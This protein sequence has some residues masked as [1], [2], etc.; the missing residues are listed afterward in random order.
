MSATGSR[1][2]IMTEGGNTISMTTTKPV[3]SNKVFVGNVPFQCTREEFQ[4]SFMKMDGFVNA[5]IIR[6]YKSKLSR[7]FGFVV[8]STREHAEKLL[9]DRNVHFKDR[10]LRFSPYSMK[11]HSMYC[12]D[13][14]QDSEEMQE[15]S[16]RPCGNSGNS[17]NS[18]NSSNSRNQ[19]QEKQQVATHRWNSRLSLSKNSN[20]NNSKISTS[21][22]VHHQIFINNLDSAVTE[23]DIINALSKFGTVTSCYVN[24]TEEKTT[25]NATFSSYDDFK[26]VL[27]NAN[28]GLI[29]FQNRPLEITPYRHS[30]FRHM[31]TSEQGRNYNGVRETGPSERPKQNSTVNTSSHTSTDPR[32]AYREG[33]KAG[34]ITG[35]QEGFQQGIEIGKSGANITD[36]SSY[37]SLFSNV[38]ML[39][40]SSYSSSGEKKAG[41]DSKEH[42][43]R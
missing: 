25:G 20:G 2:V 1:T 21:Y 4:E 6:R 26:N 12:Y 27:L 28:T 32:V 15:S 37:R 17:S 42:Q 29:T 24:T 9:N 16:N 23:T 38:P 31:P 35:F 11:H 5:D 10:V 18:S 40:F 7:G 36:T 13:E 14:N 19:N 30:K 22:K 33:F 8:F 39:P 3:S 34:H 41:I 43:R